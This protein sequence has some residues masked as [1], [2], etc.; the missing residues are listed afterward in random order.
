MFPPGFRPLTSFDSRVNLAEVF[1]DKAMDSVYPGVREN[2]S[3]SDAQ[4]GA[5]EIM[6]RCAPKITD[7]TD[8]RTVIVVGYAIAGE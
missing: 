1:A 4:A 7:Q 2:T 8:V 3:V 6:Q 5:S